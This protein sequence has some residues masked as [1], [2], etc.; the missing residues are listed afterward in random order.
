MKKILPTVRYLLKGFSGLTVIAFL[1]ILGNIAF[2]ILTYHLTDRNNN[3]LP[4]ATLTAPVDVTAGVFALLAGML[5]LL[6]NFRVA[7]ANG[8][9]RKTFLLANLPAAAV[10]AFALALI[11]I[12]V[13]FVISL[14]QPIIMVTHLVYPQINWVGLLL[15]QFGQYF[16]LTVTGWFIILVYYRGNTRVRWAISLAPFIL[17]GLYLAANARTGGNI[18][19]ALSEFWRLTM[20]STPGIATI[21]VMV[22]SAVLVI[23]VYLLIRRAPI[24]N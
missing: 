9:S 23:M 8:V 19:A 11:N 16:L 5:L 13:V 14:F 4:Q 1:S 3:T 10:L 21:T 15:V 18:A 20:R 7:L 17:F 12:L 2:T 6:A 22:Y 24:K